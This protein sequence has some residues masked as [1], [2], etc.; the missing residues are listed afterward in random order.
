[1]PISISS[2]LLLSEALLMTWLRLLGTPE[3]VSGAP[4]VPERN[5]HILFGL[6][7]TFK[8]REVPENFALRASMVRLRDG[9]GNL[10][11][12]LDCI[13]FPPFWRCLKAPPGQAIEREGDA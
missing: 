8:R 12:A 13:G 6:A 3:M 5:L 1:M 10:G 11:I 9:N 2:I 4:G 7:L